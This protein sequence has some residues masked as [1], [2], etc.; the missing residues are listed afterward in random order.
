MSLFDHLYLPSACHTAD[1]PTHNT[2]TSPHTPSLSLPL[3]ICF[4]LSLPASFFFYPPLFLPPFL[5]QCS[6]CLPRCLFCMLPSF[7]L[8][9]VNLRLHT[10]PPV[11][12]ADTF[13][14]G[15]WRI[16][17]ISSYVHHLPRLALITPNADAIYHKCPV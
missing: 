5:S 8:D 15:R 9:S 11:S 10:P 7:A 3:S 1:T 13:G 12:S 4:S 2:P 17:R 14:W 16:R 6:S